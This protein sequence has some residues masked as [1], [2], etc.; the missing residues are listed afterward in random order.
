MGG[1]EIDYAE[2]ACVITG[3]EKSFHLPSATRGLRK[4]GGT[5]QSVSEDMRTREPMV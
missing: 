1:R 5:V 4:A 3:A 2:L